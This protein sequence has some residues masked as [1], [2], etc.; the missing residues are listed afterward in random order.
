MVSHFESLFNPALLP[1]PGIRGKT[2]R[3]KNQEGRKSSLQPKSQDLWSA[4]N[5][6]PHERTLDS[7]TSARR[8]PRGWRPNVKTTSSWSWAMGGRNPGAEREQIH[9]LRYW[10]ITGIGQAQTQQERRWRRAEQRAWLKKKTPHFTT[11]K[12]LA[13][14]WRFFFPPCS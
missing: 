9:L 11:L 1:H 12:I 10:S 6:Q 4:G 7:K 13:H 5:A 14:Q 3:G 8:R 2:L